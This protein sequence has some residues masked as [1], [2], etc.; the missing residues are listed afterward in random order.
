MA[1]R[2]IVDKGFWPTLG[3]I[4][5]HMA[6]SLMINEGWIS[7]SFFWAGQQM[8]SWLHGSSLKKQIDVDSF[9]KKLK[10]PNTLRC[11]D[12]DTVGK[13]I[14]YMRT[15][16]WYN[17]SIFVHAQKDMCSKFIYFALFYRLLIRMLRHTRI[18]WKRHANSATHFAT[19]PSSHQSS[20]IWTTSWLTWRDHSMISWR[21]MV[22]IYKSKEVILSFSS[23]LIAEA[24]LSFSDFLWVWIFVRSTGMYVCMYVFIYS[25]NNSYNKP[26]PTQSISGP[27]WLEK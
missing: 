9:L 16:K 20:L 24:M 21:N 17:F 26:G 19:Q 5:V 11:S 3:Y 13:I 14:H 4:E 12:F 27:G 6:A 18:H 2:R 22:G 10:I 8:F 25:K 15:K 23:K 1:I 7:A